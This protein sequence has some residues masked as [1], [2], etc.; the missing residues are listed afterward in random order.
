[1]GIADK[2]G[3]WKAKEEALVALAYECGR[4]G[5]PYPGWQAIK[6]AHDYGGAWPEGVRDPVAFLRARIR[7]EARSARA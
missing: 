2:G 5:D 1:M 4:D 3:W 7:Q 6:H